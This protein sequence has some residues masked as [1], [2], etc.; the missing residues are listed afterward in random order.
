ML[1]N[2]IL[3]RFFGFVSL[4]LLALISLIFQSQAKAENPKNLQLERFDQA[5]LLSPNIDKGRT[6][7]Q[8][9]VTCHGPE[10]WGSWSGSY[11]QIAGQ[12]RTVIIKQLGDISAGLRGNPLMEAFTSPRVLQ[13]AQ[14]IA[15]L[16]AYIASL[17]MS[18]GNG[19]GNKQDIELGMK[20]YEDNCLQCHG[21]K[22]EGEQEDHIPRLQSQH[23]NYLMRQFSWIRFGHRNNAD[24]KM[25]KQIQKFTLR[26]QSAVMSYV[27]SLK[28]PK[29]KLAESG[30]INPDYPN[31]DRTWSPSPP[32]HEPLIR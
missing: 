29:E 31:Y 9:C 30:W 13:S 18:D 4:C 20:L 23:Y 21:D 19:Q 26:E 6:L 1:E 10:G 5:L 12:Y 16:A 24:Q 28:P 3:K 27:A 11:P 22:G 7:Y 14:D 32:R 8:Y 15:D 25:A 17:P 2:N